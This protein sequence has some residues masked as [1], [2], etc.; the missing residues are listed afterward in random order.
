MEEIPEE[1]HKCLSLFEIN[2]KNNKTAYYTGDTI[3]GT[4]DI[5]IRKYIKEPSVDIHIRGESFVYW[6]EPVYVN[7]LQDIQI[8]KD[9]QKYWDVKMNLWNNKSD[10]NETLSIGLHSFPFSIQIPSKKELPS[11][12]ESRLGAVRYWM[13]VSVKQDMENEINKHKPFTVLQKIDINEKQYQYKISNEVEKTMCCFCFR[14]GA[15]FLSANLERT[16]FCPGESIPVNCRGRNQ[17]RTVIGGMKARLVQKINYTTSTNTKTVEKIVSAIGGNRI[18]K[19][20]TK[21]WENQLLKIPVIPPTIKYCPNMKV[22]YRVQITMVIPNGV[23]LQF[24]LPV[25]IGT[26]PQKNDDPYAKPLAKFVKCTDGV[27]CFNHSSKTHNFPLQAYTPSMMFVENFVFVSKG[28][29]FRE[30]RLQRSLSNTKQKQEA[31]ER[32]PL[33][34][35]SST[36]S[37]YT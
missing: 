20:R 30:V 27:E 31:D 2:L 18:E 1:I 9:H 12:F 37:Y 11:S 26:I 29:Q 15:L 22:S 5:N 13:K 36:N 7:G 19:G 16:G 32:R 6:Q 23:D 24:H 21:V 34:R 33:I 14:S 35:S 25:T 17:A 4:V 3:Y 28:L 8:S 10:K